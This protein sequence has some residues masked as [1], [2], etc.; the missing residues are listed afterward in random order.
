[1]IF[2]PF[3]KKPSPELFNLMMF[4]ECTGIP[5]R[6]PHNSHLYRVFASKE[7]TASH[8][9]NPKLRTPLTTKVPR[10][11]I[12]QSPERAALQAMESLTVMSQARTNTFGFGEVR[13]KATTPSNEG[14]RAPDFG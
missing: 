13:D 10:A 11:L 1:M 3:N 7:W 6:F 12:A 4:N 5:T 9:L 8:C 2:A 14:G